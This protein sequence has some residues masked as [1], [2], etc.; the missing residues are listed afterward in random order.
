MAKIEIFSLAFY[1]RGNKQSDDID[2]SMLVN[3]A[4]S[5]HLSQWAHN[6]F[7]RQQ[8]NKIQEVIFFSSTGRFDG[9]KNAS[10]VDE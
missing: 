10:S 5:W 7:L 8:A 9:L 4:C 3:C 6:K 2:H 1:L